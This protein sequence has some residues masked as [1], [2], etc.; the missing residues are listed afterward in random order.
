MFKLLTVVALTAAS[1]LPISAAKAEYGWEEYAAQRTCMYLYQGE[2][3][4][5]AGY[6]GGNDIIGSQY[7]ADFLRALSR[8]DED[9]VISWMLNAV[10]EMCPKALM[11]A[12]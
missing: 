3:A 7:E 8:Y 9:L 2:T 1:L 5:Q 6:R 10:V 12:S 11:N 4:Y